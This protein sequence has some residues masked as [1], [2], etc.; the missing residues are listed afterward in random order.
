[1]GY[2]R[3]KVWN[4]RGSEAG[5]CS[6]QGYCPHPALE[7]CIPGAVR[8]SGLATSVQTSSAALTPCEIMKEGRKSQ[9]LSHGVLPGHFRHP[10]KISG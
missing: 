7:A 2:G 5:H 6:L 1:M 4:D 10:P 9:A 3:E 8:M